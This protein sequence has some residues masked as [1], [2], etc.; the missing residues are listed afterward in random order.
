[1]VKHQIL[2]L[3][4]LCY[5][6]LSMLSE[7]VIMSKSYYSPKL[8]KKLSWSAISRQFILDSNRMSER[9]LLFQ[10]DIDLETISISIIAGHW[11]SYIAVKLNDEDWRQNQTV[12]K[13]EQ[14]DRL[15]KHKIYLWLTKPRLG[16]DFESYI[17]NV[18]FFIDP[19]FFCLVLLLFLKFHILVLI[20]GAVYI[21]VSFVH[22]VSFYAWTNAS[23]TCSPHDDESFVIL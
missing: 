22:S 23:Y 6:Y 17:V 15:S 21:S 5:R 11:N 9:W 3:T 2:Y 20:T 18:V 10:T 7:A 19:S 1:M 4:Q 8:R 16:V 13:G 12:W 14:V